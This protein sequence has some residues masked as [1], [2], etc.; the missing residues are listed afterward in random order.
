MDWGHWLGTSECMP[1]I[2]CCYED[3]YG[4]YAVVSSIF[5][6]GFP[7]NISLCPCPQSC[8]YSHCSSLFST[9]LLLQ[10]P[11][12]RGIKGCSVIWNN[13]NF[14]VEQKQVC[15]LHVSQAS[16]IIFGPRSMI[17]KSISYSIRQISG[18][19]WEKFY[20]S[21]CVPCGTCS[22]FNEGMEP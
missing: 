9:L 1:L 15:D 10:P 3:T 7:I 22:Y 16:S 11:P 19:M 18:F 4:W 12:R 5:E 20:V 8:Y 2:N 17:F 14:H 13:P 6:Q 21:I